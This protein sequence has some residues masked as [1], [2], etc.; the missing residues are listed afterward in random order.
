VCPIDAIRASA[1]LMVAFSGFYESQEPPP[2][3]NARG[4]VPPQCYDHQNGPQSGHIL[5][6]HFV[7][8]RPGGCRGDM[9][10]VVAQCWCLVAFMKALDLL[11][12][13]M[14]VVLHRHTNMLIKKACGGGAFVRCRHLFINGCY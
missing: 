3:G 6:R 8:C 14:H 1:R 4:V 13:A 12:W 9:E 10:Q 7:C 11:H 5:H 2:F